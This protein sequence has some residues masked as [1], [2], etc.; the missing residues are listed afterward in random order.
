M[1]RLFTDEITIGID[2]NDTLGPTLERS[3]HRAGLIKIASGLNEI[4][5]T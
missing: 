4:D 1:A 2:A 5:E 3:P